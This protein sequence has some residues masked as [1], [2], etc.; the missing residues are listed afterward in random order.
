VAVSLVHEEARS[1]AFVYSADRDV[2]LAVREERVAQVDHDAFEVVALYAV[3][4]R[5]PC[6]T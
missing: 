3:Y 2:Q 5:R 4:R 6:Q 1:S